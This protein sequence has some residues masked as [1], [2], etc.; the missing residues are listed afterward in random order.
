MLIQ[1][2]IEPKKKKR[3]WKQNNYYWGAILPIVGEATG[4]TEEEAHDALKHKFLVIKG[5]KL[6]KVRSTVQ[7]STGEFTEYIMKITQWG[8]EFLG[9]EK[10]PEPDE[11]YDTITNLISHEGDQG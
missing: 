6:D 3:S 1:V 9:I 2:S 7:L 5:D 4:F 8:S 10:W 11:Y